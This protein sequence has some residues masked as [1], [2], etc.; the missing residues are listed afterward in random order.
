MSLWKAGEAAGGVTIW[1]SRLRHKKRNNQQKDIGIRIIPVMSVIPDTV[2]QKRRLW[3]QRHASSVTWGMIIPSGR[4]GKAPN[5]EHA[6]LPKTLGNYLTTLRLPRARTATS[7][8]GR[9]KIA[10]H[11]AFLG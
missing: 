4:C 5:T 11:G 1:E 2:F 3:I 9:M 6:G 7:R 8:M 10:L